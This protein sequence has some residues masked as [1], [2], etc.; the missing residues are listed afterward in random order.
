[1]YAWFR[2]H[3]NASIISATIVDRVYEKMIID[4]KLVKRVA[5]GMFYYYYYYRS[6]QFKS[7][8]ISIVAVYFYSSLI[9]TRSFLL[10][11]VI[12]ISKIYMFTDNCLNAYSKYCWFKYL[13]GFY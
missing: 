13:T 6:T 11:R 4:Q 5:L 2:G 10:K 7:F 1:M 3:Q 9:K 12:L 8:I